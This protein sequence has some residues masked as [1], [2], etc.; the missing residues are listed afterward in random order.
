M[1]IYIVN[2]VPLSG[3][4]TFCNKKNKEYRKNNTIRI[5]HYL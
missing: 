1:K 3:K 5:F 4:T 2:G